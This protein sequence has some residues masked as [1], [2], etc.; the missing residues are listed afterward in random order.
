MY[1]IATDVTTLVPQSMPSR[2][3]PEMGK[4]NIATPASVPAEIQNV[5]AH[6]VDQR[7]VTA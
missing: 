4:Q 6:R 5:V 1:P 2:P 3:L 7:D